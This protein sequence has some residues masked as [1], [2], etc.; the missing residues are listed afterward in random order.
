MQ[1]VAGFF[2]AQVPHTPAACA[3]N[4]AVAPGVDP[5]AGRRAQAKVSTSVP[6]MASAVFTTLAWA[7]NW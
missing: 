6:S 3:F 7:M 1:A 4:A 2:V 5:R